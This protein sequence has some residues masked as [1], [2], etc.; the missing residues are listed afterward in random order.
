MQETHTV[1][2]IMGIQSI[3]PSHTTTFNTFPEYELTG[4]SEH[5]LKPTHDYGLTN[6]SCVNL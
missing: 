5:S 6:K 2:Q 3:S 4:F 1:T